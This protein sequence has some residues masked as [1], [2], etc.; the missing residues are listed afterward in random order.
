[1][2][3]SE[4]AWITW[5]NE[6]YTSTT[7]TCK[8]KSTYSR[9]PILIWCFDSTLSAARSLWTGTMSLRGDTSFLISSVRKERRKELKSNVELS[10]AC[11][12]SLATFK[13]VNLFPARMHECMPWLCSCGHCMTE[14]A[15]VDKMRN[16]RL[17]WQPWGGVQLDWIMQWDIASLQNKRVPK[18]SLYH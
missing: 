11:K 3:A 1:M 9:N 18:L 12:M 4:V 6:C 15:H 10:R 8:V 7:G 2:S 17:F 14:L 5:N 13:K 16:C